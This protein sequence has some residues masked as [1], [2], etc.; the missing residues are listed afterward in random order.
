MCWSRECVE[1]RN[2]HLSENEKQA[3]MNLRGRGR[4][5][6]RI[7]I[8]GLR[9]R[10]RSCFL[11]CT[12]TTAA[13]ESPP[14][15]VHWNIC[16]IPLWILIMPLVNFKPTCEAAKRQ[17]TE[18]KNSPAVQ[19]KAA[20]IALH[21]SSSKLLLVLS[22]AL[23][24]QENSSL[25]DGSLIKPPSSPWGAEAGNILEQLSSLRFYDQRLDS[26][27]FFCNAKYSG[28]FNCAGFAIH[29]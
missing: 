7:L 4:A 6:A 20:E 10:Y 8:M 25:Y 18:K 16:Q 23:D 21:R 2:W 29:D 3:K 12:H 14:N 13:I 24:P 9:R 28:N 19:A 15:Q 1:L 22:T 5:S 27:R 11:L 17:T 26:Q